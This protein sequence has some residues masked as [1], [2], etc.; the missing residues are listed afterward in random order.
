MFT[1]ILAGSLAFAAQ[2]ANLPQ[3]TLQQQTSLRCSAAFALVQRDRNAGTADHAEYPEM[4]VR[5]K[6]FFVRA[7]AQIMEETGAGREQFEAMVFA[8]IEALSEP[9]RLAEVMPGCLLLLDAS[10]I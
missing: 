2:G 6:E 5:G 7:G 10:G 9:Q 4:E 3:L 1:L 8:E